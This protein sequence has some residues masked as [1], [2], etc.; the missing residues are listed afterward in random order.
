MYILLDSLISLVREASQEDIKRIFEFTSEVFKLVIKWIEIFP[1]YLDVYKLCQKHPHLFAVDVRAAVASCGYELFDIVGKCAGFCDRTKVFFSTFKNSLKVE[2]E[3]ATDRGMQENGLMLSIIC[4]FGNMG[5]F[6][7][8]LDFVSVGGMGP[9]F[10]CP[11]PLMNSAL[12]QL[13]RLELYGVNPTFFKEY[14]RKLALAVEKRI[15]PEHMADSEFKEV[16]LEDFKDLN[17]LM[18]GYQQL[19]TKENPS[20]YEFN[21]LEVA[22][23]FL[24]S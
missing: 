5:G 11:I 8:I 3:F 14:T 2:S 1:Q 18:V 22:K 19:S 16:H 10:K 24:T 7:K 20:L 4:N 23:R 13:R 15:S 6:Q 12:M 9:D 21:E 17:K